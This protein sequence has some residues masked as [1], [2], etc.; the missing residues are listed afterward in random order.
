MK[1]NKKWRLEIGGLKGGSERKRKEVEA[2]SCLIKKKILPLS[3]G[4]PSPA[5][6]CLM[7]AAT[8]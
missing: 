2:L 1:R 6:F 8:N 7:R 3:Q 4:P 5:G